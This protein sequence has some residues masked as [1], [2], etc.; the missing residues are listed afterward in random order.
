MKHI[1]EIIKMEN[2]NYATTLLK[3]IAEWILLALQ[4]WNY[5]YNVNHSPSYYFYNID[6]K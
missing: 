4:T 2:K 5:L 6:T 3:R 1:K